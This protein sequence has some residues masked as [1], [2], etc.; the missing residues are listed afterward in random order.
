MADTAI[1]YIQG[2]VQKIEETSGWTHFF[3]NVGRDYPVKLSTKKE[4]LIAAARAISSSGEVGSWK[5]QLSLGGENPHRPGTRY[6]NRRLEAVKPGRHGEVT[7]TE[8]ELD[9]DSAPQ[10][11][12]SQATG[13]GGGGGGSQGQALV[14]DQAALDRVE[15]AGRRKAW[16]IA[17]GQA[18]TQLQHTFRNDE[19]PDAQWNRILERATVIVRQTSGEWA[20]ERHPDYLPEALRP[21]PSASSS[22]QNSGDSNVSFAEGSVAAGGGAGDFG[23]GGSTPDDDIPF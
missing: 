17:V 11:T 7:Q 3:I 9:G 4:D 14:F 21:D 6:K 20:F 19:A 16:S 22:P 5:Y 15:E 2:A 18:T 8:P 23:D 12:S 10:S 13:G 1:C